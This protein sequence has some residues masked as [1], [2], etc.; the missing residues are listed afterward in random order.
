MSRKNTREWQ[1]GR[2]WRDKPVRERRTAKDVL[3]EAGLDVRDLR[4]RPEI[5]QP[6]DCEGMINGQWCGVEHTELADEPT[7]K[8]SI[9]A[10]RERQ[11]GKD[12]KKPEAYFAWNQASLVAKLQKIIDDKDQGTARVKGERPYARYML[13]IETGEMF[14]YRDA[15]REFLK[16]ASFRATH[17]TDVFLSL[18]YEHDA[19]GRGYYPVFPFPLVKT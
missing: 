15:V 9:K 4:S 8:R 3:T 10:Q 18:D 2:F 19:D 12:P 11:A 13:V 1:N 7:M 16:D 5:E 14:L 17:I 6:P